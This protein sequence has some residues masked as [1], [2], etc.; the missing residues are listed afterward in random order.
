MRAQIHTTR[1]IF[2]LGVC[3]VRGVD[4]Y[5]VPRVLGTVN[6][7]RFGT[8]GVLCLVST[9]VKCSNLMYEAVVLGVARGAEARATVRAA[10][11]S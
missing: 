8:W 9:F 5:K 2:V 3:F 1:L 11:G 10:C 7:L 4:D 6:C